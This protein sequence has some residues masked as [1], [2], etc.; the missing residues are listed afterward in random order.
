[1]TVP[2]DLFCRVV[3]NLGD[4]GV[5]WR[6]AAQ[7][8]A[9]DHPVRLWID[10]R[11]ALGRI[12][13]TLDPG[14]DHQCIDGV[15]VL[16]WAQ[17]AG[18]LPPPGGVVIEAF[19]CAPPAA[20]VAA[21]TGRACLWINLEYLSAENWVSGYHG[22]PSLQA[23]GVAKYFFFPGFTTGTG[24]LLREPDLRARRTQAQQCSRRQRLHALCARDFGELADHG[25]LVFLFCY[26]GA[27]LAG[28]QEA[29]IADGTPTLLLVPGELPPALASRRALQVRAIPFVPQAQFDELLWCCDLNFVR[30]ED[31][32]VRAHWAG[33]P[34]VWQIYPQAE[35][36]HLD[37]LE[38]WMT[39][40]AV[41]PAAAAAIR[42]WNDTQASAFASAMTAALAPA[43][44]GHWQA[45][46]RKW[47][48]HLWEQTDLARDLRGFCIQRL[49]KG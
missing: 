18:A 46:S 39:A 25:R 45:Q 15:Q 43:A 30:G 37:K 32:L 22:L 8:A 13:P 24:G 12:L 48:D 42:A 26:P 2:F 9:M 6:L 17:A 7:L 19:A 38:A 3:D 36:T 35:H 11:T 28:L 29:L 23:N 20:Y 14:A 27:P 41:P 31:S 5:C 40:A 44:F 34:L 16:P 10:D 21:M 49:Q 4:A 1:M 47:S 33:V